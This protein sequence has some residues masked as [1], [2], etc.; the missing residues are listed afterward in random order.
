MKTSL[1]NGSWKIE[2]GMVQKMQEIRYSGWENF[3]YYKIPYKFYK[4][5][6]FLR[7]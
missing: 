2:M 3:L 6:V 1:G 5:L 4:I 7:L